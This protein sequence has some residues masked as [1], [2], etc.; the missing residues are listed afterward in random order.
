MG[1]DQ[2]CPTVSE[3]QLKWNILWQGHIVKFSLGWGHSINIFQIAL[4][5]NPKKS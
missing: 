2:V 5:K 3:F 4:F 1:L